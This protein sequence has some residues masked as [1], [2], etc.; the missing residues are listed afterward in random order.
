MTQDPMV[1]RAGPGRILVVDDQEPNRLLLVEVL[2]LHGY[3][4]IQAASG[5]E[6]LA[7][8][9]T[10]GVDAVLLDV[11]MPGMGGLEVCRALRGSEDTAALPILLVTALAHREQRLEGIAAGANDYITKPV[12]RSDLLLR[13]RNAVQ[14]G[15]L[16]AALRQ[17]Y[18]RLERLEELRDGLVHMLVHDLRSPLTAITFAVETM[19]V[20]AADLGSPQLLADLEMLGRQARVL[21]EMVTN[22]LDVSRFEAA[23]MPLHRAPADLVSVVREALAGLGPGAHASR[24][25]A[26]LPETPAWCEVDAGVVRR[27]VSNLVENA[28]KFGGSQGRVQVIVESEPE[29]VAVRVSDDG[30]GIP[31]EEHERIFEK[32]GRVESAAGRSVRGSGLGLTFCKLAV[33]A[34]GGRIGVVS[35]AGRGA[36]FWLRL[37]ARAPAATNSPPAGPGR[38]DSRAVGS[39]RA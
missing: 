10:A 18:R 13:V 7:L 6:A 34:H 17:Q 20:E 23:A 5:P 36:T 14:M 19:R 37:P 26:A 30:P 25:A 38:G 4:T 32:F 35:D 3:E 28:L 33:E 21:G 24:V 9:R 31:R 8:V 27:V 22:M 2:D 15:R 16:H 29:W 12:D 11:N 39:A 1:E